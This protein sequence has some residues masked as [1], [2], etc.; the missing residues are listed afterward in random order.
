MLKIA[1]FVSGRGSN[2]K[3]VVKAVED[4]KLS[5]KVNFVVSN[6]RECEAFKFAAEK[7]I[8]V[9]CA[10]LTTE[11]DTVSY[12]DLAKQFKKKKLIWLSLRDF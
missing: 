11:E 7:N 4:K 12:E 5:A 1:I 8:P 10:G 9:L 3:A 2:L 6:K